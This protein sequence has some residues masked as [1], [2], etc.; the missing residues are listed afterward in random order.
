MCNQGDNKNYQ[1]YE[2]QDFCNTGG[3][4]CDPSETKNSGN[5]CNDEKT[6]I[7]YSMMYLLKLQLITSCDGSCIRSSVSVLIKQSVCQ[8]NK[9]RLITSS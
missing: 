8:H 1:E 4:N 9:Y 2:E 6:T 5:Y 3:A 7:Q